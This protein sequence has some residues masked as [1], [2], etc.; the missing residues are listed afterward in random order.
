MIEVRESDLSWDRG[1]NLSSRGL[2]KLNISVSRGELIAVV[3]RV[4]SGKTSLMS[5]LLGE[6]AS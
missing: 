1:V 6:Y 3:G 4:G 2:S 5:A